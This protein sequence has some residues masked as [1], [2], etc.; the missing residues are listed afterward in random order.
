MRRVA[1]S[2]GRNCPRWLL[3]CLATGCHPVPRRSHDSEYGPGIA[4]NYGA[5]PKLAM[6][7]GAAIAPRVVEWIGNP[8]WLARGKFHVFAGK[9][10]I[11]KS[12]VVFS[13]LAAI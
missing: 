4:A 5:P 10:G 8:G 13:I 1:R 9:S 12:S 2:L 11:G 3:P 7:S 6:L